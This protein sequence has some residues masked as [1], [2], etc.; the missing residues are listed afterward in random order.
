MDSVFQLYETII[1]KYTIDEIKQNP[2]SKQFYFTDEQRFI[3]S[4]LIRGFIQICFAYNPDLWN[5]IEKPE[6]LNF[7]I[8]IKVNIPKLYQDEIFE[9][10]KKVRDFCISKRSIPYIPEFPLKKALAHIWRLKKGQ[11]KKGKKRIPFHE[12]L[13]IFEAMAYKQHISY[14]K[15]KLSKALKEEEDFK[16]FLDVLR[17]VTPYYLGSQELHSINGQMKKIKK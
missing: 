11:I 10:F 9:A 7:E 6:D 3:K 16:E 13:D 8:S 12:D 15:S 5:L 2:N 4:W 1:A 17:N 14:E